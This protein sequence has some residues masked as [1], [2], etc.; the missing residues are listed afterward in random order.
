[1]SRAKFKCLDCRVD[2]G[3]IYEHYML[4]DEVWLT[5][6]PKTGMLC[7]GCV[8]GRLGRVLVKSDFND[9]FVNRL[10]PQSQRLTKRLAR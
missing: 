8:E 1:M 10:S 9:S 4:L 3:K 6:A 2:T 5:V 7:I